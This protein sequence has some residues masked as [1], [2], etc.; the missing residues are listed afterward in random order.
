MPHWSQSDHPPSCQGQT[1]DH[2]PCA[3]GRPYWRWS[4]GSL[5]IWVLSF[6]L[7]DP[8]TPAG[9][10]KG[11][12]CFME[13]M[14]QGARAWG[15]GLGKGNVVSVCEKFPFSGKMGK[16]QSYK[17]ARDLH[18]SQRRIEE[19]RHGPHIP[20]L[21]Q[22]SERPVS[23]SLAMGCPTPNQPCQ[24]RSYQ[25]PPPSSPLRQVLA[26]AG[27]RQ[28]PSGVPLVSQQQHPPPCA[29]SLGCLL[30]GAAALAGLRHP[31]GGWLAVRASWS[32]PPFLPLGSLGSLGHIPGLARHEFAARC[33]RRSE[34]TPLPLPSEVLIVT[35]ELSCQVGRRTERLCAAEG[36]GAGSSQPAEGWARPPVC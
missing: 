6:S 31:A 22:S 36:G 5:E 27:M 14:G 26:S 3:V 30:L 8:R 19:R 15:R 28:T 17:G 23:S 35:A 11:I 16:I 25:P 24:E 32:G 20:E 9:A 12:S 29:F 21:S 33:A 10:E 4:I 18:R 2:R 34:L 13:P 7:W 1:T